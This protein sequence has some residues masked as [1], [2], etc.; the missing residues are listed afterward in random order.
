MRE[1][2]N[3]T[4]REWIDLIDSISEN[5]PETGK[6]FFFWSPPYAT[7]GLS[8]SDTRTPIESILISDWREMDDD[9]KYGYVNSVDRMASRMFDRMIYL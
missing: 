3:I 7:I 4:A 5:G 2:G 8:V 9:G 1:V 6:I